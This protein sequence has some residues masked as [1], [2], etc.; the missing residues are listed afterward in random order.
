LREIRD[1]G[2]VLGF[3]ERERW[4]SRRSCLRV[5]DHIAYPRPMKY[6]LTI[7]AVLACL[8]AQ[9]CVASDKALTPP[10]HVIDPRGQ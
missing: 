5:A 6:T 1:D 10:D 8:S 9:G 7:L 2:R 3:A 4:L